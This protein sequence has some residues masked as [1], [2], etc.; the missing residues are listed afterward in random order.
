M[1]KTIKNSMIDSAY[2]DHKRSGKGCLVWIFITVIFWLVV[3]AGIFI[4]GK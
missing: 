1:I 4:F 2:G 3:I